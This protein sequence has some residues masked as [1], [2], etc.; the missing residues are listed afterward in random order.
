ME[1]VA[2]MEVDERARA[3]AVHD[4]ADTLHDVAVVADSVEIEAVNLHVPEQPSEAFDVVVV[5]AR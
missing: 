3:C 1:V 2:R 4:L 5:P